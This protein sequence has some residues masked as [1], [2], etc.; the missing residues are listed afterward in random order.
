MA[1]VIRFADY[2]PR[3]RPVV[4]QEESALVIVLP[5]I[6][7][8]RYADPGAEGPERKRQRKRLRRHIGKTED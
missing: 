7:I 4:R 6:R 2:G 5:V 1:D 8:E 3:Y